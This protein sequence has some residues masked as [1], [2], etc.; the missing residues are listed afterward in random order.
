MWY[1]PPSTKNITASSQSL[2][3][4]RHCF[5]SEMFLIKNFYCCYLLFANYKHVLTLLYC[6]HSPFSDI[7]MACPGFSNLVSNK[8]LHQ[9]TTTGIA[10]NTEQNGKCLIKPRTKAKLMTINRHSP[11][12]QFF[13]YGLPYVNYNFFS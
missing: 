1:C 2:R 12:L 10:T 9:N 5:P 4:L 13:H 8:D 6:E 7:L 11:I 3:L